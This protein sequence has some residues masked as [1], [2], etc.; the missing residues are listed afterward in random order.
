L[1]RLFFYNGLVDCEEYYIES[2]SLTNSGIPKLQ[3][4]FPY[5]DNYNVVTGSFPTVG[6][7]SLLFNNEA[8]AYGQIPTGSL[9]TQYW[10]TYVN[11]LYNPRTR[12]FNCEAIIP[13]AD[14]YK[15]ELND[16]V[17]WRGNYY[18][19]RAINDYN[20]KNGECKIQLLGPLEPP[21]ISNLLPAKECGF[22][23][24]SS[25]IVTSTTTTTTAAPTTTTT[26]APTTTTS[27]TIAPTTTTTLAPT[28]TTTTTTAAPT[29]TTTTASPICDCLLF[30]AG[31]LGDTATWTECGGSAK[32]QSL[33]SNEI[34]L[35]CA[36]SGSG[37]ITGASSI[38][39]RG[40]NIPANPQ[41]NN[42]SSFNCLPSGSCQLITFT[43][44]PVSAGTYVYH[45]CASNTLIAG[46]LSINQTLIVCGVIGSWAGITGTGAT[47]TYG[48]ACTI[49]P[50]TTTTTTTTAAPT[51]TTTS[52][53][54]TTT[55]TTTTIAPTTTTTT[56][57]PTTTTTL[58]PQPR[59]FRFDI[60]SS[61]SAPFTASNQLYIN[62]SGSA[63]NV[64]GEQTLPSNSNIS[65][66][67]S[68][69]ILGSVPFALNTSIISSSL[70]IGATLGT[71]SYYDVRITDTYDN[72]LAA[73]SASYLG[74]GG[75]WRSQPNDWG[76]LGFWSASLW[77]S[78]T[79]SVEIG[80]SV[81]R[82]LVLY[83]M[84]G[85]N[86]FSSYNL[87]KPYLYSSGSVAATIGILPV[88]QSI[89]QKGW[90][91]V[92]AFNT[93]YT[94][95]YQANISANRFYIA[96]FDNNREIV[97]FQPD[98]Y[99]T[100]S[101]I[102]VQRLDKVTPSTIQY[103]STNNLGGAIIPTN[104]CN[105]TGTA[106]SNMYYNQESSSFY[107]RNQAVSFFNLTY[108]NFNYFGAE[109]WLNSNL[110]T[111]FSSP[112]PNY[113]AFRDVTNLEFMQG[114]YTPSSDGIPF[115][116]YQTDGF[117]F[118]PPNVLATQY[119]CS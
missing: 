90:A 108:A 118:T 107:V 39:S 69:N 119:N 32:S 55:T 4:A 56:I 40:S 31:G 115:V 62:L 30:V 83:D 53:T 44:G 29:T 58:P 98:T 96:E 109:A 78:V 67:G 7:D 75:Q 73:L 70:S 72:G 60:S 63:V 93:D 104:P 66:T 41:C 89:M 1:P 114:N 23:F 38:I 97:R 113:G 64:G 87:A 16:I 84:S 54:S 106:T 111:P 45:D 71:A 22:N 15:M 46:T 18:H 24:T 9:Y 76:M 85:S 27:T 105:G 103:K 34:L 65:F 68:A 26:I 95:R 51:T 79:R 61:L 91:P 20:L 48:A 36:A 112:N 21:V 37:T 14:Y 117:V 74:N 8:A 99:N 94:T 116:V 102:S 3:N 110:T 5:F 92:P 43:Q 33:S 88:S 52:T 82:N 28:T 59:F 35:V 100:L 47:I 12:L 81:N 19:L 11:L 6:S 57:T 10:E 49:T 77:N 25:F 86:G 80:L 42:S 13:L 17:E 101:N 2:G 50:T